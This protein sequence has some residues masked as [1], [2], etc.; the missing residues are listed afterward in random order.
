[1][2]AFPGGPFLFWQRFVARGNPRSPVP[3][4]WLEF[5]VKNVEDATA[6]LES[7]GFLMLVKNKREPWGQTVTRLLSPEGLLVGV[8]L[9]R[10]MRKDE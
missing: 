10:S 5:D 2:A 4:A 3:Q 8:T 1:V 6:C 7:Q 9:T